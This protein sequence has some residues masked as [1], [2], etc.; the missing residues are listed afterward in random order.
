MGSKIVLMEELTE[1]SKAALALNIDERT[2]L[3]HRL[4][5]SLHEVDREVD[6]SWAH[7][8]RRR[9]D[10]VRSGQVKTIDGPEGL[11]RVRSIVRK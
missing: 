4:A 11:A 1:I 8:I 5:D 6:E 2:I 3:A 9:L 7:E 10:D